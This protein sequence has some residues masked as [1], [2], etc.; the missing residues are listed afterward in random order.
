MPNR[1]LK[2]IRQT[3]DAAAVAVDQMGH[4]V[5]PLITAMVQL[6]F[7]LDEAASGELGIEFLQGFYSG[8][9]FAL[10][11]VLH[12]PMPERSHAGLLTDLNVEAARKYINQI[13]KLA[14]KG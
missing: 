14:N 8:L 10:S 3:A 12:N 4:T 2:A 5:N 1:E 6:H 9:F 13:D 11:W 7:E